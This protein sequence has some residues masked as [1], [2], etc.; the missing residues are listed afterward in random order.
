MVFL[1]YVNL[2]KQEFEAMGGDISIEEL[3]VNG[4]PKEEIVNVVDRIKDHIDKLQLQRIYLGALGQDY[5][6]IR[7]RTLRR[8]GFSK[9]LVWTFCVVLFIVLF[10]F[11]GPP[12]LRVLYAQSWTGFSQPNLALDGFEHAKTLWD[13]LELLIIPIGLAAVAYLFRRS[14]LRSS[15]FMVLERSFDDALNSYLENM[16]G[17]LLTVDYISQEA[18]VTAS[19][20]A[21]ARTTV[22]LRTLDPSRKGIVLRFLYE[23]GLL[24]GNPSF[25]CLLKADLME[26]DFEYSVLREANLAGVNLESAKLEK[27]DLSRANLSGSFAEHARFSSANLNDAILDYAILEKADFFMAKLTNTSLIK[28]KA[29]KALFANAFMEKAILRDIDLTRSNLRKARMKGAYLSGAQ[30]AHANLK[31][32]DLRDANLSEVNLMYANLKGADLSNADLTNAIVTHRQLAKARSIKGATLTGIRNRLGSP[33][34][35]IQIN[36]PVPSPTSPPT[37]RKR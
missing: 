6:M 24:S 28:A 13:W 25:V 21:T 32:A 9:R 20:I 34:K 7:I 1:D 16:Q 33:Q 19:R 8:T 36:A 22:L 15:R 11:I 14:E 30:M 29:S 3:L 12:I 23:A 10:V 4:Y 18:E 27:T 5:L 17:L 37:P 2:D 26:I 31:H 35:M